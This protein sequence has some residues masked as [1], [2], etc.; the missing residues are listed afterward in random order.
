MN[1]KK[2]WQKIMGWYKEDPNEK[3]E[4]E[5]FEKF[6]IRC[7]K[8]KEMIIKHFGIIRGDPEQM[9]LSVENAYT[10]KK[11]SEANNSLMV[12]TWVLAVATIAFTVGTVYGVSELNNAIR[13]ALQIIAGI[14]VIGLGLVVVKGIWRIIRLK[15]IKR[16]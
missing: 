6:L 2:A 9:A 16:S 13:I 11:I 14:I 1:F 7:N 12:A 4:T 15:I 8:R 5:E 3:Q 10:Q